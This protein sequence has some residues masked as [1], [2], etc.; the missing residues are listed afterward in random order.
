VSALFNERLQNVQVIRGAEVFPKTA[1]PLA[2]KPF[3]SAQLLNRA[4]RIMVNTLASTGP[5][6][7][8]L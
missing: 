1:C 3:S 4:S 8:P 2:R 5:I 7:I 6:V